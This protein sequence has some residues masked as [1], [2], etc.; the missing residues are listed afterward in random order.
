MI[1][2]ACWLRAL[3]PESQDG[4]PAARSLNM[5]KSHMLS[6]VRGFS[7]YINVAVS[8][9]SGIEALKQCAIRR[10]HLIQDDYRGTL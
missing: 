3:G 1:I 7:G 9:Q 5:C 4:Y 10:S 6:S 2:E 8:R